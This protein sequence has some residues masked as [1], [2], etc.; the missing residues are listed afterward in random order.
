MDFDLMALQAFCTPI[1]VSEREYSAVRQRAKQLTD[2]VVSREAITNTLAKV[3][4][5]KVL[6]TS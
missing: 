3:L 5:R 6:S 2:S 1:M 4:T